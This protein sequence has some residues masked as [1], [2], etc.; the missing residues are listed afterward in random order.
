ML[1]HEKTCVIP[2]ISS[3]DLEIFLTTSYLSTILEQGIY[4]ILAGQKQNSMILGK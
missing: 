2:I 3:Q 4:M 1:M